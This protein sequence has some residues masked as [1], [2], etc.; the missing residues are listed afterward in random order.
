MMNT[1]LYLSSRYV[2]TSSF[3]RAC[4]HVSMDEWCGNII[5]WKMTAF[6]NASSGV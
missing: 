6:T 3:S 4:V 1:H 2:T 5:S